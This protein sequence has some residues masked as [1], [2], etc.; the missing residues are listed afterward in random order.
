[1]AEMADTEYIT[2][3]AEVGL[4]PLQSSRRTVWKYY[5]IEFLPNGY[6]GRRTGETLYAHPIYGPYVIADYIAQYRRTKD[7][8]Y[9]D[10]AKHVADAAIEQMAP[11]GDGLAF[12]YDGEKTAVSSRT[13]T[14]YSGLTQSRYVEV[15]NKLVRLPGSERFTEP[16]AAV[17][18]SLLVPTDEGGVA[19]Y[20]D[21]GGLIIE[22]Y[23]SRLPDCTLNGWTT[24]TC[25]LRDYAK[26]TGDAGGREAFELSVRGLERLISLYD[27]PELSNSR[28][29]LTGAASIQVAAKGANLDV[30]DCKVE[31]PGSGIFG[32]AAIGDPAGEALRTGPRSVR[33]G[34]SE[35]LTLS[36]SRLTWPTPNSVHLT[37]DAD[38]P[39][40]LS[41]GIG[42]GAYDPLAKDLPVSYYRH[43]ETVSLIEGMNDVVISVPW[44]DAELISYPT[45]FG[46]A[47]A[48][49]QFNQYHWIHVDTLA[50]IVD[51]T[52]SDILRYFKE[53]WSRYPE[54]WKD[55]PAYQD[56]RI[57]L[58][59][60]DPKVHI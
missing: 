10:A 25:I 7:G 18:R 38:G 60:F 8:V 12:L 16:L 31:M 39:G 54:G 17:V 2:N 28:Y 22:E 29:R 52:G 13:G 11:V 34:E 23:P 45:G 51:A 33:E 59:R 14:F 20:T 44:N 49:R 24:A 32:A 40:E 48:N 50:K 27:V 41:L 57:T 15:L 37:V 53:K 46:K 19:R 21:N 1:M 4:P 43:L 5:R 47:L 35:S 36:L 3:E 6:P 26:E 58:D 56:D 42:D 9:L 55:I 30:V